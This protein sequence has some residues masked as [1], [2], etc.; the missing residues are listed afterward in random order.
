VAALSPEMAPRPIIP[1]VRVRNM[2]SRLR[3]NREVHPYR[4]LG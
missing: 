3:Q 2:K 1:V 4:W